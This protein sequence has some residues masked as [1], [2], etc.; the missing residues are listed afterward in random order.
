M[1]AA[2]VD[3]GRLAVDAAVQD[4]G[5]V[6]AERDAAVGVDGARLCPRRAGGR[7][8]SARRPAGRPRRSRAGRPRTGS[9][10]ARGSRA[11]AAR[12]RRERGCPGSSA[13]VAPNL[14]RVAP[15][16]LTGVL[17]EPGLEPVAAERLRVR[18]EEPRVECFELVPRDDDIAE[19]QP[20]DSA[21]RP[22]RAGSSCAGSER[23]RRS[24]ER[25]DR[26]KSSY[27]QR[28]GPAASMTTS[29]SRCP[30][31]THSAATYLD[32]HRLHEGS[33]VDPTRK[34]GT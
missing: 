28:S 27:A 33:A 16:E 4:D 31:S 29:S 9:R 11:A 14:G 5:R 15:P 24:S 23:G 8:R 7:A 2:S 10:A 17:R 34:I 21:Q 22:A 30:A 19:E 26:T 18:H 3:V 13:V 20:G 12:S 6:D 1:R 32:G 25:S